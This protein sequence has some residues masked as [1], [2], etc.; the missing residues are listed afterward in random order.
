ML[1]AGGASLNF[2]DLSNRSERTCCS[3]LW[4]AVAG[5]LGLP[6]E[7]CEPRIRA[8]SYLLMTLFA[9]E[10]RV[11]HE[12]DW[13]T[14]HERYRKDSFMCWKIT[15]IRGVSDCGTQP[16]HPPPP[17]RRTSKE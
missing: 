12:L 10:F 4:G 17:A 7:L 14:E 13:D 15:V 8:Q 2:G 1:T 3:R 16:G 9:F 6:Q 11:E 5:V